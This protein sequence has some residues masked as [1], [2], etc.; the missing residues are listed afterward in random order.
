MSL[1]RLI[2]TALLVYVVV[3]FVRRL[4]APPSM[5]GSGGSR[6]REASGRRR[7]D[8]DKAIHADFEE[9]DDTK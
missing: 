3:R 5:R 1:I 6:S 9:I 8:D 7:P 2:I 4:F